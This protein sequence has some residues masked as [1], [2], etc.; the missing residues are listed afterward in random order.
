MDKTLSQHSEQR[1][2]YEL[3]ISGNFH[4]IFL[5]LCGAVNTVPF[6][7]AKGF[8]GCPSSIPSSVLS[9]PE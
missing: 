6:P 4:V 3:F 5:D 1:A 9:K 7:T 2:I 8:L